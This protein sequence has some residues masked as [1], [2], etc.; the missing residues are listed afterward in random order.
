MEGTNYS[1]ISVTLRK[2]LILI[3]NLTIYFNWGDL[4]LLDIQ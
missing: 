1:N 2:R 4:N 3:F